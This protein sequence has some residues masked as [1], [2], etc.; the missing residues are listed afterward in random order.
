MQIDWTHFTPWASLAGGVTIGLA[1]AALVLLA[2]RTLGVS[3]IF[4]GALT[5]RGP[6]FA[7]RAA[8]LL[9]LLAAPT[10]LTIFF[11]PTPPN[12][13]MP[14]T[15]ARGCWPPRRIRHAFG[16]WL[17]ERS[18]HLRALAFVSAIFGRDADFYVRRLR[19]GV[20]RPS[21]RRLKG[22][23]MRPFI[24]FVVGLVFGMGLYISGM[25]QPSKVQGFLDIFG[26]W[27][28]SLAF[29]MAGAVAVGLVAFS[30]AKR[31]SRTFLGD[32]LRLPPISKIDAPL[33]VGSFIFGV[34]WGLSGICPGPGIFNVGFFDLPA[35]VF[36]VSMAAG[37]VM[38][39][40]VMTVP[41]AKPAAPSRRSFRTREA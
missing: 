21:S 8:F 37:M 29:V 23:T 27:D 38:E 4:Y 24:L 41:A 28:P 34:G 2:G 15:Q 18:W 22:A 20:C 16:F 31:R 36:V 35:L 40:L 25:T 19:H 5:G 26:H 13:D 33:V 14:W 32:E 30:I 7:W 9:G 39:R 1:A 12:I 6:E 3:G 17:H 11:T 10:V